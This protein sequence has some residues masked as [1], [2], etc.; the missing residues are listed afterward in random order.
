[1]SRQRKLRRDQ[2][3]A[4]RLEHH[5]GVQPAP[6]EIENINCVQVFAWYPTPDATG[7]A[8]Q[9][10]LNILRTGHALPMV[11]RIKSQQALEAI[12]RQLEIAGDE[13]W[14]G[15]LERP[16]TDGPEAEVK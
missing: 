15:F 11:L 1:M 16:G 10:H 12:I 4:D 9:V 14:G 3:A 13:C 7:P 6:G 5:H 2:A 8:T